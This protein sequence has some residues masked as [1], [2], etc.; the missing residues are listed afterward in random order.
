[1]LHYSRY[2]QRE[3][4]VTR[5]DFYGKDYTIVY[6]AE[7]VYNNFERIVKVN[8]YSGYVVLDDQTILCINASSWIAQFD[9][10]LEREIS[11]N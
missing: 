11:W 6:P 10:Y 2:Q 1:M 3:V 9:G 8:G 4:A 5:K 7:K